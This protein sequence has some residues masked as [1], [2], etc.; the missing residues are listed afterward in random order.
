MSD[1]AANPPSY[2]DVTM[3]VPREGDAFPGGPDTLQ[4][5]ESRDER[6][7]LVASPEPVKLAHLKAILRMLYYSSAGLFLLVPFMAFLGGA[8]R[9]GIKEDIEDGELSPGDFH[10][11][12]TLIFASVLSGLVAVSYFLRAL[13]VPPSTLV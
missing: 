3:E 7:S 9:Y 5:F 12:N 11:K 13:D 10:T 4:R 1:V 2:T 6:P 8:Y